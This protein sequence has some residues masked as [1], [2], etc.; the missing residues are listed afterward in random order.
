MIFQASSGSIIE[1]IYMG[2]GQKLQGINDIG[3]V[4]SEPFGWSVS[5]VATVCTSPEVCSKS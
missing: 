3:S 1:T 2:F 5:A 4:F